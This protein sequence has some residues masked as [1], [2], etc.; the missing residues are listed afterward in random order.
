MWLKGYVSAQAQAPSQIPHLTLNHPD[1]SLQLF[2]LE[3]SEHSQGNSIL[4]DRKAGSCNTK[5]EG[6]NMMLKL[7]WNR[8]SWGLNEQKCVF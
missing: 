5:F 8:V 3:G 7:S 6:H 2:H 1:F 4:D